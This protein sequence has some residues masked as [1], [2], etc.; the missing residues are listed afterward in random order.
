MEG[1]KA[2][3]NAQLL[4]FPMADCT[5]SAGFKNA[6]YRRDYG[7]THYGIDFDSK[8]AVDFNA[9]ASGNGV[10]LGVE[11]NKN[12]IGGVTVIRYD[13][14][15]CPKDKKIR[16]VIIRKYH[17][18]KI[19]VKKGDKVTALQPIAEVSGTDKYNNHDHTEID[20]DVRYP[21]HT[22]QVAEGSSK[23]LIRKGATDKTI[24][25]PLDVL[26]ISKK[27]QVKVHSLA[28]YADKVKDAPRYYEV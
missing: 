26:V 20:F 17:S 4:Y 15:Y 1:V 2:P 19:I 8:K 16:S 25:N 11:M 10:V 3:V 24:V 27:Q 7:Y 18:D 23:L 6:K 14:V 21:F 9:L 5:I 12:A 13:N 22:P 28:K